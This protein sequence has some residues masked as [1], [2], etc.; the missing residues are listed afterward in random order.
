MRDADEY[1][2]LFWC[3]CGFILH[4]NRRST[5]RQ[6]IIPFT[7]K[8]SISRLDFKKASIKSSLLLTIGIFDVNQ[9][10]TVTLIDLKLELREMSVCSMLKE[11]HLNLILTNSGFSS[12]MG[13][14]LHANCR[15]SCLGYHQD[16]CQV[17]WIALKRYSHV[18]IFLK[19]PFNCVKCIFCSKTWTLEYCNSGI[20]QEKLGFAC[21]KHQL[22]ANGL[23]KLE[24]GIIF[25]LFILDWRL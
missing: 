17:N 25:Y 10:D 11:S 19:Y 6:D 8:V 2:G 12:F 3:T 14:Y 13:L 21:S 4:T 23:S 7:L 18:K 9:N 20:K 5:I 15:H 24:D 16:G 1:S 22:A